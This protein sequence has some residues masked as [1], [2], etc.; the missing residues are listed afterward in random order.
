M[1]RLRIAG[2]VLLG[3][4]LVIIAIPIGMVAARGSELAGLL[5][6]K[7]ENTGKK[8]LVAEA[9]RPYVL[10]INPAITPMQ[11]GEL[12]HSMRADQDRQIFHDFPFRTGGPIVTPR[13][14]E[15]PFDS[16]L[17]PGN[18]FTGWQGPDFQKILEVAAARPTAAQ[19]AYLN[20]IASDP[21]WVVWDQIA[22]A[23]SVDVLGGQFVIPFAEN[24]MWYNMP[25]PKFAATKE[26]A[27]AGIARAA[28]H[29]A[30]QRPDSAEYAL[31]SVIAFGFSMADNAPTLIEQL[32]G[33]VIVGIGRDGLQRFY[34]IRND[35]RGPELAAR[36]DS[37]TRQSE[38]GV[39]LPKMRA[40]NFE[41]AV[42]ASHSPCTNVKELIFGRSDE[43]Q[44][45]LDSYRAAAARFP[46]EHAY[47]DLLER[48]A[49]EGPFTRFGYNNNP[50]LLLRAVY[51]ASNIAGKITGNPRLA[52]CAAI[53]TSAW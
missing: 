49:D 26:I 4:L 38:A 13:W 18:R 16:T 8:A 36:V 41:L 48:N 45:L 19:R 15:V 10:P 35:P 1:R 22:S 50:G 25:I 33:V 6:I 3:I 20:A 32:I 11:A 24:A 34:A 7:S 47:F 44:A 5:M 12:R 14:R 27:Y 28:A 43:N 37:L 51:G 23:A 29:L 40:L 9:A 52:T 39:D 2:I 31:R 17:F 42:S 53:A 30:A 46:S 21:I